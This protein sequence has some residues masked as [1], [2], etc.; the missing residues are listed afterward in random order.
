LSVKQSRTPAYRHHRPSD[1]AVVTLD[2]WDHYL[3]RYGSPASRAEYDRLLGEWLANGRRLPATP[4]RAALSVNEVILTYLGHADAYYRK[5]GQP[6]KEP[7]NIR[8]AMRPLRKLYGHT[9]AEGFGPLALKTVQQALV[10][11]GLT[12][13]GVNMRLDKIKRMFKWA[14][15]EELVPASTYEALRTVNGLRRGRSKAPEGKT[16]RPAPDTSVDAI[17]PFVSR[18]V[19]AMVELQRLTGMRSGEVVTMRT[20]DIDTSG[21]VWVYVP[22]TH[23]TEH[24][25]RQR[26]VFLGPQAQ[27]VLKAWL[28]ADP[29]A[30][31]F[32]P[33]EAMAER[34]ARMRADRATKVQPSQADRR[35]RRPRKRPGEAYTPESYRRAIA[36]ACKRAGVPP[37]HPHQL[38]HSAATRLR[39]EFGIDV[40]RAVLGHSSPAVTEVYA[41]LDMTK[42]AEAMERV[43]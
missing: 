7:G 18:Q 27:A 3:G 24:H 9:P 23:K 41:E 36:N 28:R 40:T 2:G 15:S 10:D 32:S 25:D 12:R 42:A 8:L 33:A 35:K 4:P 21:K 17:K 31:L 30:P 37:W 20:I 11:S 16:V 26:R 34:R 19:W 22:S 39:R 38:R 29:T 6:T 13:V 14:A 43:G 5:N 1:Q